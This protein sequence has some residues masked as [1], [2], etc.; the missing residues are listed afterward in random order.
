MP[1]HILIYPEMKSNALFI[2]TW[3]YR[4][5]RIQRRDHV[6][7]YACLSKYISTTQNIVPHEIKSE[8]LQFA[9]FHISFGTCSE[10]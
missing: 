10:L 4:V 8:Q 3:D 7:I 2:S 6:L 9:V 5:I 1:N